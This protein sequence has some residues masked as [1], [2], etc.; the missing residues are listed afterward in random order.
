MVPAGSPAPPLVGAVGTL[1][2]VQ[3]CAQGA[4][5]GS[6]EAEMFGSIPGGAS[7]TTLEFTDDSRDLVY[8]IDTDTMTIGAQVI[9]N[10]AAPL[11]A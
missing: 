6:G 10:V 11:I 9:T 8:L 1:C 7:G 4:M 2:D 5:A 3:R